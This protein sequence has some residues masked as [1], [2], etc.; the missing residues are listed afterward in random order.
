MSNY[1]LSP[2]FVENGELKKDGYLIQSSRF[3]DGNQ[4]YVGIIYSS[5][6]LINR[7][8]PLQIYFGI[9][10]RQDNDYL[11]INKNDLTGLTPL[12]NNS[13]ESLLIALLLRNLD[14][15]NELD[16]LITVKLFD[17]YISGNKIKNTILIQPS[18]LAP[19]T[20]NELH[21]LP[22]TINPMNYG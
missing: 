7:S 2:A 8:N 12:V 4:E 9:N 22:T 10:V 20:N 11:Y 1:Y 14:I 17:K 15:T 3:L 19:I 18:Y 5:S 13:A 16:D 6:L 21:D